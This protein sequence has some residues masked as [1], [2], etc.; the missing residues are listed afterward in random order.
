VIE[1]SKVSCIIVTR[2]NVDLSELKDSLPFEDVVIWDNSKLPPEEDEKVHGRYCAVL[3]AKH[4]VIAFQDD[5]CIV[6]DWP[7][8]LKEYEPG[9]VTCNMGLGH[10]HQY[11]PLKLALVG[12]GAIFDKSLV[13]PAFDRYFALFPADEL[14]LRECDRVFT[15]LNPLKVISVPYRHLQ[16]EAETP[17]MWREHRHGDDLMEIRKRIAQVSA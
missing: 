10:Q 1:A 13:R 9:V 8:L 5:D 3:A 16:H 4:E 6:Q 7:T 17:R 12:F 15:G 11:R 14:F 2:G